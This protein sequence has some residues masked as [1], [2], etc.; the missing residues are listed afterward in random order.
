[1]NGSNACLDDDAIAELIDAAHPAEDRERLAHLATCA[2]CRARLAS[3]ARLLRDPAISLEA[4]RLD[5]AVRARRL[6]LGPIGAVSTAAAAVLAAILLWPKPATFITREP[7][8]DV[9]VLRDSVATT[10]V[11]P[12]ILSP[13]GPAGT[14]DSLRWTSVAGGDLYRITVWDRDGNVIWEGETRDTALAFPM[15]ITR[16]RGVS[17][18]WEIDARIGWDRWVSSALGEF[19]IRDFPRSR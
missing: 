15:E 6:H 2:R 5:E 8:N 9:D 1:M 4:R 12:R 18:L 17:Y 19:T 11:A 10:T 14:E 7:A 16:A 13:V 3:I